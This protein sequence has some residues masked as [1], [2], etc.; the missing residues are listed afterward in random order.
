MSKAQKNLNDKIN[1]IRAGK[2]KYDEAVDIV[3]KFQETRG[4]FK[5]TIETNYPNK[6]FNLA[7]IVL[8]KESEI[9]KQ[10]MKI[11]EN[12]YS[13]KLLTKWADQ[14]LD[15][16]KDAKSRGFVMTGADSPTVYTAKDLSSMKFN[17]RTP[18]GRLNM[19]KLNTSVAFQKFLKENGI[20]VPGCGRIA[21]KEGGRITFSNGTC[22]GFK[23]A[24]EFAKGDPEGF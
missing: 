10:N 1:D 2:G 5:N 18:E 24:D 4:K 17:I 23:N 9:V 3:N 15:I 14:G 11:P 21:N 22:G 20:V 13:K 7:D 16:A 6:N 12:V 19:K 8:G